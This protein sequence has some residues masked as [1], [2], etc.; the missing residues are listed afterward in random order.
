MAVR[1]TDLVVESVIQPATGKV[2]VTDLVAESIIQPTSGKVRVT[3][4]LVETICYRVV[5][6]SATRQPNVCV[7]C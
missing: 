5:G 7:I 1:E 3:L 6:G 4:L 2:R